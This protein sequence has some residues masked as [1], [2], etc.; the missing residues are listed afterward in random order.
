MYDLLQE[1][2]VGKNDVNG[3]WVNRTLYSNSMLLDKMYSFS[4]RGIGA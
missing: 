1:K 4:G 2:D 3:K